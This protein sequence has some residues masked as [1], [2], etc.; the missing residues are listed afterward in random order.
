MPNKGLMSK[1]EMVLKTPGEEKALNRAGDTERRAQD[2]VLS[3][4]KANVDQSPTS[5]QVK[6]TRVKE[7]WFAG[8]HSDMYGNI[9][10]CL[11]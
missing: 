10:V 2:P 9:F 3:D 6:K 5:K 4:G 7:V 1:G 11:H 8:S